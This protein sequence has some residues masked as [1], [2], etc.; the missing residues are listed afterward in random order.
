MYLCVRAWRAWAGEGACA[1]VLIVTIFAETPPFCFL[2]FFPPGCEVQLGETVRDVTWLQNE[3]M[4]AVAQKKHVYIYDDTGAEVHVYRKHVDVNRLEY[5]PYHFLLASVGN[6]GWLK[7]HDVSEGKLVAEL[8]TKLGPCKVLRQNP[9]NAVLHCGH[10]NG[11]VTLW[12]PNMSTFAVKQLC[13]RGPVQAIAVDVSGLYMATAGLDG[14]MKVW[15][16]RN[17][18]DKPLQQYFTPTPATCLDISQKNMLAV[19]HGSH[20]QVW[21]GALTAKQKSPLMNHQIPGCSVEQCRFSPFEDVLGIGHTGG[22]SSILVPGSGEPNFD[23]ME[24]NVYETKSQRRETEVK[25]LLEKVPSELISL[26]PEEILELKSKEG[27]GGG[28]Y[29]DHDEDDDEPQTEEQ[30]LEGARRQRGRNSSKMRFLRKKRNVVD[31]Q[32]ERR[33]AK[34]VAEKEARARERAGP[35]PEKTALDRFN[36]KPEF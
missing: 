18:K 31:G 28:G 1:H 27:G 32:R 16:I 17:F 4:F 3:T 6:A 25:R 29:R 22:F 14:Q 21:Q 26:N 30:I 8:R 20:V 7:Y 10:T 35:A 9:R 34:M 33:M 13:H 23:A 19:G 15:D 11:T 24:A 2:L 36:R 12:T 5:L